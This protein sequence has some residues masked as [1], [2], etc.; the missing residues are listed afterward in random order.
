MNNPRK[1]ADRRIGIECEAPVEGSGTNALKHACSITVSGNYAYLTASYAAR[2]T[3]VDVFNPLQPTIAASIQ[4][5]SVGGKTLPLSVDV[6]VAN[7]FAY[8][9]DEGS[10]GPLTVV[11]VRN[12]AS[13][14][15]RGLD[16]RRGGLQRRIPRST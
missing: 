6:Q 12:H 10:S 11:D 4:N 16:R 7:G 3:V 14:R 1:P 15:L 5:A 13:P 8:V 9:A 2:L